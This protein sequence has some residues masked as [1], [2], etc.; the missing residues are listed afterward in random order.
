MCEEAQKQHSLDLDGREI[1][2]LL[3]SEK[4]EDHA[5]VLLFLHLARANLDAPNDPLAIQASTPD[6]DWAATARPELHAANA[7]S[8]P[9][10]LPHVPAGTSDHADRRFLAAFTALDAPIR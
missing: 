7:R 5:R 3:L 10:E 6:L 2:T 4:P 1:E 8:R 9:P